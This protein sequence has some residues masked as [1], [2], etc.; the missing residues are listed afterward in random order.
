MPADTHVQHCAALICAYLTGDDEGCGTLR[1][2]DALTWRQWYESATILCA[3]ALNLIAL[4][5]GSHPFTVID[6][7]HPH[8]H[9]IFPGRR[10][11]PAATTAIVYYDLH[12]RAPDPD[13]IKVNIVPTLF[14]IAVTAIDE[15]AHLWGRAPIEIAQ[16]LTAAAA[17][18][19]PQRW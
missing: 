3:A 12:Q 1:D 7:C 10:H 4:D 8:R 6:R 13:A 19:E 5:L 2:R 9:D 11:L 18:C 16:W 17:T 14:D 15:L